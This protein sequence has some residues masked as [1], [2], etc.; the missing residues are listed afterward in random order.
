MVLYV[1]KSQGT[2][3]IRRRNAN[4]IPGSCVMCFKPGAER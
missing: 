4:D 3:K 1:E 2:N